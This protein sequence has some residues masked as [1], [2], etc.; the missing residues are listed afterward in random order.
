MPGLFALCYQVVGD[1]QMATFAAFGGF[2]TLVLAGFTETRRDRLVAHAGLAVAGSVLLTIGT[3]V[4]SSVVPAVIVTLVVGFAVLFFGIVGANAASGAT[5][6]L[7]AFVLPAASPGTM[8]MLPSRLAGWWLASVGGTLAV[9]A[10]T[11]KPAADQVCVRLGV[12][13]DA[14]ADELEGAAEGTAD[15][16]RRDQSMVAKHRLRPR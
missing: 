5:A 1:L 10:F 8:S 14:L 6:A 4:S 3:A 15:P 13:A 12:F 2:A 11:P 7:L 9:L 16:I